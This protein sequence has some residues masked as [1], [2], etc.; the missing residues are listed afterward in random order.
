[1]R[2]ADEVFGL[3]R[4]ADPMWTASDPEH[5]PS[6]PSPIIA[7]ASDATE[8]PPLQ[9]SGATG[10]PPR[11]WRGPLIAAGTFVAV[12]VAVGLGSWLFGSS[13]TGSPIASDELSLPA[14]THADAGIT[15]PTSE[16]TGPQTANSDLVVVPELVGL[17]VFQARAKVEEAGMTLVV[18]PNLTGDAV[19]ATQDPVAGLEAASG[20][21]VAVEWESAAT[22]TMP[23]DRGD[24]WV[25]PDPPDGWAS[26]LSIGFVPDGFVYEESEGHETA[27]FHVFVSTDGARRFGV[28]RQ[29]SPPPYPF[30]GDEIDRDGRTFTVIP[31]EVRVLEEV[32]GR[33]RIEVVSSSLDAETLM[34][35][36]VG[37]TYDPARD[38]PFSDDG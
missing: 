32:G 16:T 10:Q 29:W 4:E 20:S 5:Q 7:A 19:V 15:L 37:V 24:T 28:G 2:D 35:I 12:V 14:T 25:A 27:T 1:M 34:R 13:G 36:A 33:V 31:D 26:G 30:V 8:R 6:D 21:S 3:F 18:P 22:T 38:L 9:P 17:T 23:D 11:A